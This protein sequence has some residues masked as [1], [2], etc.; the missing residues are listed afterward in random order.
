MNKISSII[1]IIFMLFSGSITAKS[2]SASAQYLGNE[3]VL[4][5]HNNKKVLFDPIFKQNYNRFTLV[6]QEIKEKLINSAAPFNTINAIFVTHDH[7]DHFHAAEVSEYLQ[8]HKEVQLIAPTQVMKKLALQPNYQQFKPQLHEVSLNIGDKPISFNINSIDA[9]AVRIPHTGWPK[10]TEIENI[11]YRVT[12]DG[13]T[14]LHLGDADINPQHYTPYAKFWADKITHHAFI[15]EVFAVD[16]HSTTSAKV[17]LNAR[18]I[19]YVHIPMQVPDKIKAL[20]VDYF[21]T[22]GEKRTLKI[23]ANNTQ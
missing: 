10:R 20:A 17:H 22:P 8:K 12:I 13:V 2:I 16:E 6:P 9:E 15:P 1:T 23:R 4:I 19:T 18:N 3:G 11:V 21:A 7:A 14:V 5:T